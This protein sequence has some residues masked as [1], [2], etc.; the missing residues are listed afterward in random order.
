M[1]PTHGSVHGGLGTEIAQHLMRMLEKDLEGTRVSLT[2]DPNVQPP[3]DGI[4]RGRLTAVS[5]APPQVTEDSKPLSWQAP[6]RIRTNPALGEALGR[7]VG[8]ATGGDV[9]AAQGALEVLQ[10]TPPTLHETPE[11]QPVGLPVLTAKRT[12]ALGAELE[13]YDRAND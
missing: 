9:P 6:D 5:L 10:A 11:P 12:S 2:L 3:P 8:A 7:Y 1:P 13:L 4:L